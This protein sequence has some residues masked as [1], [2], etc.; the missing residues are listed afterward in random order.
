M[1]IWGPFPHPGHAHRRS[2]SE[3]NPNASSTMVNDTCPA[4]LLA[5]SAPGQGGDER[6]QAEAV[7]RQ[8]ERVR[9]LRG[10]GEALLGRLSCA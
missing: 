4:S 3:Y 7:I 10:V 6:A 2:F 5:R 9:G 1:R 8:R